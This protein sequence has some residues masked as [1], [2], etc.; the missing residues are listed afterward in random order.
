MP[1]ASDNGQQ[2]TTLPTSKAVLTALT[3]TP[4]IYYQP[5]LH[6]NTANIT[7]TPDTDLTAMVEATFTGYAAVTAVAFGTP[8]NGENGSAEMFAPSH[9]F[10]CSGGTP[11]ETIYGWYLTDS[12]GTSLYLYVPLATPVQIANVGD[13][14]TVQ[15]AVQYSGI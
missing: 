9:T 13:Q 11:N 6:L 4:Q 8:G 10:T 3:A 1:S 15:P 7:V 2:V 14:V 5:T 12:G